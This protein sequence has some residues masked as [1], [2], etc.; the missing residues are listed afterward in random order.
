MLTVLFASI[1]SVFLYYRRVNC[2]MAL[3][4]VT[5]V[6]DQIVYPYEQGHFSKLLKG[7]LTKYSKKSEL[8]AALTVNPEA[9]AVIFLDLYR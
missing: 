7:V 9:F 4:I 1:Y 6:S 3:M 8:F 5:D 2:L